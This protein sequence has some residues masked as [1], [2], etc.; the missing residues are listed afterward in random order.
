M[1]GNKLIFDLGK[2]NEE[3]KQLYRRFKFSVRILDDVG[4][5]MNTKDV[6]NIL[7]CGVILQ[8]TR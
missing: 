7:I 2:K 5:C 8:N 6:Y 1:S 3:E 4:K